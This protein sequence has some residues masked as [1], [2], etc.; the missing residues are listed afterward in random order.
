MM[1]PVYLF[2]K[3]MC[4]YHMSLLLLYLFGLLVVISALPPCLAYGKLTK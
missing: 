1:P 3:Q 2:R 4:L